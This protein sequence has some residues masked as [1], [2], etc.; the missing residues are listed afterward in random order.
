MPCTNITPLATTAPVAAA[1]TLTGSGVMPGGSCS[2]T[3]EE[4]RPDCAL[5]GAIAAWKATAVAAASNQQ[6]W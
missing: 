3:S 1:N 6:H 4:L 5:K 2:I